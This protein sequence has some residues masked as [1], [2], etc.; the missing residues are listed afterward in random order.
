MRWVLIPASSVCFLVFVPPQTL[1]PHSST[2]ERNSA[3]NHSHSHT[4]P[5]SHTRA[6][7]LFLS[8]ISQLHNAHPSKR[9]MSGEMEDENMAVIEC[10]SEGRFWLR[11]D[12]TDT[13]LLAQCRSSSKALQQDELQG[14]DA[15][16]QKLQLRD[17]RRLRSFGPHCIVA[18]RG[19][20]IMNMGL[21][22]GIVTH[23]SA[24]IVVPDGAEDMLQSLMSRLQTRMYPSSSDR[25]P[26]ELFF[27]ESV[28]H[29]LVTHHIKAVEQCFDAARHLTEGG[30]SLIYCASTSNGNRQ[31]VITDP[32]YY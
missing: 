23:C 6:Q 21:L 17:I 4:L 3:L 26:F 22:S 5:L 30:L 1:S 8:D 16:R 24:F 31:V 29:T 9:F 25:L 2:H 14:K 28:L 20:V 10:D 18:R 27:V 15:G 7:D 13:K 19:A 11:I 32:G 12:M